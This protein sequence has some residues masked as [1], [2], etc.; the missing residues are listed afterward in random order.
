MNRDRRWLSELCVGVQFLDEEIDCDGIRFCESG[1]KYWM[2]KWILM[3]YCCNDCV[4]PGRNPGSGNG[5]PSET[6]ISVSWS[7]S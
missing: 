5:L 6:S 2:K 4:R 7:T 3:D 1:D